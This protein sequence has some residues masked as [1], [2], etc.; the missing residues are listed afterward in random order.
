MTEISEQPAVRP[1]K[2]VARWYILMILVAVFGAIWIYATHVQT[3]DE[4][5]ANAAAHVNFQAPDFTLTTLDGSSMSLSSLRGKVVLVNFWAT[6]CPPCRDEMP[7][8]Q[9]VAREHPNDFVVLGIDNGETV[10]VVKP[11]VK[12]FNLTFPI[13]LDPDFT[14]ANDYQVKALPTS[15]FIDRAGIVRATNIGAMGRS[16]IESQLNALGVR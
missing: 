10:D 8:I 3:D 15:F 5:V 4:M 1:Q 11:F 6:W 14:V 16:Y 12:E 2:S 7:E 13:L 9:A